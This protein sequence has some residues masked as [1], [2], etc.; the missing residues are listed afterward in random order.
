LFLLYTFSWLPCAY[1][2][3]SQYSFTSSFSAF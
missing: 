3:N 1:F 2:C